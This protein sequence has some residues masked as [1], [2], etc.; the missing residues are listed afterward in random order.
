[1]NSVPSVDG[2]TPAI[3]LGSFNLQDNGA[4]AR[5]AVL[6]SLGL[7][8]FNAQDALTAL[9]N[10]S[11]DVAN[12]VQQFQSTAFGG[13]GGLSGGGMQ[14]PIIQD[15]KTAFGLL[16]GKDV[17][18]FTMD[19]PHFHY[20]F[21]FNDFISLLGP[22][23]VQIKGTLANDDALDINA[24]L[25]FG[26]DT[27]GLTEFF[28]SKNLSDI[29]DGFYIS[30]TDQPDGSGTNFVPNLS[31]NLGFGAFAAIDAVVFDAGVG[32]GINANVT[33]TPD[34]PDK[35]G[36]LRVSE[37]AD[38]LQRG[39]FCV[40]DPSGSF[41]ASLSAFVKIGMNTPFG[42]AGYEDD[43]NIASTTLLQ[44]GPDCA[45]QPTPTP[46]LA[47]DL[48]NG[49]LQLNLGAHAADRGDGSTNPGSDEVFNISHADGSPSGDVTVSA[50]GVDEV[51][52]GV[53]QIVATAGSGDTITF[54]SGVTANVDITGGDGKNHISYLGSGNAT[55]HAVGRGNQLVGGFGM[56]HLYGGSGA[57]SLYGGP[58]QNW[59]YAGDGGD[60]LVA[61][62]DNDYMQ[63]GSGNDHFIAGKGNDTMIGGGGDDTFDWIVGDGTPTI[64]ASANGHSTLDISGVGTQKSNQAPENPQATTFVVD[65]TPSQGVSVRVN[66]SV[67]LTASGI[68]FLNLEGAH[69]TNTTTI[70]DVSQTSLQNIYVNTGEIR[71]PDGFTDMV[72]INGNNSDRNVGIDEVTG[73]IPTHATNGQVDQTVKGTVMDV[74]GFGPRIMLANS[75]DKLVVNPGDGKDNTTITT[76]TL[77]GSITVNT[78]AG[79]NAVYVQATAGPTTVGGPGTNTF[80]V[81]SLASFIFLS[82]AVDPIQGAL[83]IKGSGADVLGV[84][85]S[86]ST[87]AKSGTKAGTLTSSTITGMGMGAK[88]ITYSG[89]G[90]VNIDLSSGG[91]TFNVQSLGAGTN[92]TVSAF[93]PT[94]F[95][96]GSNAAGVPKTGGIVDNIQGPLTIHGSSSGVDKLDIDD[97]GS[98]T[99]KTGTVTST[100]VTGLGMGAQGI[101]YDGLTYLNLSLGTGGDTINVQ[102]TAAPT[103]TT[104]DPAGSNT[105]NVGSLA[106]ALGGILD[107]I[108]GPLVITGSGADTL[109]LDDTGSTGPKTG[110]LTG[111]NLTGLAMGP[112]GIAY[113][114]ITRM[115]I[116]LGSGGNKLTIDVNGP[117]LPS[118]TTI[119]GG[120]SSQ[121]SLAA[122]FHQDFNG[123]LNLLGFEAS[124][125]SVLGNFNG[126][127]SDTAP[128]AVQS[129]SVGGSLTAPATFTAGSVDTMT[130]GGDVAGHVTVLGTLGQATIGGSETASGVISAA[131]IGTVTIGPPPNQANPGHDLAGQ[132]IASG[133]LTNLSVGGDLSGLVQESLTTQ[134]IF[135]GGSVT[136]TGQVFAVNPVPA[137]G[138]IVTMTVGHDMAG[139][140][141]ASGQLTTLT[142][143]GN[144]SG[145]V[146]ESLTVQTLSVG[147]SVT[148]TGL[149]V[150]QN[151]TPA[152]GNIVMMTVGQD[153]AGR[154]IVSGTLTSL[155]VHGGTPGTIVAGQ[156]GT[157]GTDA[158]FGPLVLQ[159]NEAGIQRRVEAAVPGQDYPFPAPPPA[160]T[161]PRSPAAATFRYFYEGL[162]SGLANPQLTARATNPTA[163]RDQYDLSLVTWNDTAKF[164]L[165]RLDANGASGIRN[166]AIEGDMLSAVSPAASAFFGS[167]TPLVAGV[168]LP[169]DALAG[170]A[171][172]DYVPQGSVQAQS[173]QELAFGQ[174]T[175][176]NGSIG[177]GA[178]AKKEYAT[179]LLTPDTFLVQAS[180]TFRVPFA[181]LYPVASFLDTNPN[182]GQF[183]PQDVLFTDEFPANGQVSNNSRGSVT[184]LMTADVPGQ[185]SVIE[186]I[187]LRGDGGAIQTSEWVGRSITSTGPLGDLELDSPQ[188]VTAVTAPSYFGNLNA[189]GPITGVVQSTGQRIDPIDGTTMT[190]LAPDIGKA[191][192]T[193]HSGGGGMTG[194]IISRGNLNSQIISDGGIS[195]LIAA[196]GNVGMATS[197]G[198]SGGIQSNGPMSGQVVVLGSILGDLT[199]HG[200]LSGARIAARGGILG[201]TTIDG[202]VDAASAVVS[203][204]AIGG[205]GTSIKVGGLKGILAA[206]GPIT[207]SSSPPNSGT[208]FNNV[209]TGTD[210]ESIADAAAIDA[211]FS[212]SSGH[213]ITTFDIA[214]LDLADLNT[215]LLPNLARLHTAKD[216][217]NKLVLSDS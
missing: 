45:D 43:Y 44:F 63:G 32:G 152:L 53:T 164:N 106:P 118:N 60:T 80:S 145:L 30:T 129:L 171:V 141:I 108:Q 77:K 74:T 41:T 59:L 139:Q 130:V 209:G 199:F 197:V 172:R 211:V 24:H 15:P 178:L 86:G 57:D 157:V 36:K 217:S 87:I 71:P 11:P 19:L 70:D 184:A 120:P 142:V 14:F 101:T 81:G 65:H 146:Q 215:V 110:T 190:A 13:G 102:S 4:D 196:A 136:A 75:E 76:P 162:A 98:T 40:F 83:V 127:M 50:F 69:G 121:D 193:I 124:T 6:S 85:D 18:I 166:V 182:S 37:I 35:D 203:D 82:S 92:A 202:T 21:P 198:R 55:I 64:T 183:D 163:G 28:Q 111:A 161:P 90:T 42:F 27:H 93:G 179:G 191:G 17:N 150:A 107:L 140:I 160:P 68:A 216:G 125:I 185:F 177:T 16:L 12:F 175:A 207:F 148:P 94:A 78:G 95:Y 67:T 1:V 115:N 200:D 205:G 99:P 137:L 154:V 9:S 134:S 61:G 38:E 138:N 159:I 104:I 29:F 23:G 204:G 153:M 169:Q 97:T 212:D 72:T 113:T 170:V 210:P 66:S 156:V 3:A 8:H 114:G 33:F 91:S 2:S 49:V 56:N 31:L 208:L 214:G 201:N 131:T 96:V 109:D 7:T 180:D 144:L 117:Q 51:H 52:H 54:N 206:K 132:V 155:R 195:G 103:S 123:V 188:G 10:I 48:G 20:E 58:G 105:F 181:D 39:A 5:T 147:G 116:G 143:G 88:G 213:F 158:G 26:Y 79:K 84:D 89:I 62:P 22:L 176:P 194:R 47:T 167:S 174:F 189:Q 122:T 128:G 73:D 34:D 149:I 133:Q 25:S 173:L 46:K 165:A 135:V 100:S 168:H 186:T 151:P 119:S 187:A 192:T 126:T 112:Q